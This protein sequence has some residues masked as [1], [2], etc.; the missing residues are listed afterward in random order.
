M[1][2]ADEVV[3]LSECYDARCFLGR[4]EFMVENA[5]LLIAFYDRREKG[6]TSYTFTNA[7]CLGIPVVNIYIE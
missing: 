1:A 4:D 7:N 3:S 5:S 6:G 2:S